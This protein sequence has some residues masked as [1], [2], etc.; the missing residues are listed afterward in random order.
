[1]TIQ[2]VDLAQNADAQK[3]GSL[4]KP[5]YQRG[6]YN[7]FGKRAVDLALV[8]LSAPFV[9]PLIA[10]LALMVALDGGRPF[11]SQLRLGRNGRTYRIWKLRSMVPDADARLEEHLKHDP[12]A[13]AEWDHSQKLKV[14]PRI[15]RFGCMLRKSS[16]DELPQLW[17]VFTG[18]MSLVGPRPMMPCQRSIYPGNDYESMRPGI[19]GPWQVSKRNTSSFADRAYYDS[20]YRERVSL[21]TDLRLLVATIRVVLRGTGY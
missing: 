20:F 9:V 6:L 19:T 5:H 4:R 21:M 16:A 17:N 8:I 1:M 7:R 14:D 11:Y 13:R 15:T 2:Y 12:N 10:F 18:E 3:V